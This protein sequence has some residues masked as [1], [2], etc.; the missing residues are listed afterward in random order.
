M[1]PSILLVVVVSSYSY[2]YILP[3]RAKSSALALFYPFDRFFFLD[4]SWFCHLQ[5]DG[6]SGRLCISSAHS[7]TEGCA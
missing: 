7:L 6:A 1:L 3:S 4:Y 5:R 2:S